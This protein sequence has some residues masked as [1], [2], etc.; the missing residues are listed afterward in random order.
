MG[1]QP[2]IEGYAVVSREGMIAL[3]DGSFPEQYPCFVGV[4]VVVRARRDPSKRKG[5]PS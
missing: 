1:Q 3:P 4:V 5:V 2:R